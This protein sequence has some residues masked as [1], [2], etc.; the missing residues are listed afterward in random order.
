[1]TSVSGRLPTHVLSPTG[2][3]V[4]RTSSCSVTATCIRALRARPRSTWT[5]YLEATSVGSR[6][7]VGFGEQPP[8]KALE[9]EVERT[10]IEPV[11]SGLQKSEI[12]GKASSYSQC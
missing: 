2:A 11:A 4:T 3:F 10:G 12:T 8:K 7:G 1:M 6:G 5:L 9:I